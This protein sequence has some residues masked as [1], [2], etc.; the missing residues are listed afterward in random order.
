MVEQE[1][2]SEEQ[3]ERIEHYNPV[4]LTFTETA[5]LLAMSIIALILLAALLRSQ[6][7][8]REL[9]EQQQGQEVEG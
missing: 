9:Q 4:T 2:I 5:G 7:R 3:I 6:R 8:I 1:Q